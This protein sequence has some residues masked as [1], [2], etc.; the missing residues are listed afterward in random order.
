MF[1]GFSE[2]KLRLVRGCGPYFL[3]RSPW[4]A[5]NN[6]QCPDGSSAKV[7]FFATDDADPFLGETL[8]PFHKRS[9]DPTGAGDP[10]RVEFLAIESREVHCRQRCQLSLLDPDCGALP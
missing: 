7:S 10:Q 1:A 5:P 6:R 9:S 3:Q 8:T 2:R 4:S